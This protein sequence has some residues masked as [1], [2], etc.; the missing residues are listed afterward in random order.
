MNIL[1]LSIIFQVL[2]T[3]KNHIWQQLKFLNDQLH[4]EAKKV[5]IGYIIKYIVPV[6]VIT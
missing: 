5:N 4:D 6:N 2:L 3:K 1:L